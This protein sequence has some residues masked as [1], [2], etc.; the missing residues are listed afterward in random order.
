MRAADAEPNDI[1]HPSQ[2]LYVADC[3][4]K[5]SPLNGLVYFCYEA[6]GAHIV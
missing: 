6:A 5:Q 1:R 4:Y 2:K 3:E